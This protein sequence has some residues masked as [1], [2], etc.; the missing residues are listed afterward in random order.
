MDQ[1][2]FLLGPAQTQK[3][4]MS[5]E[6]RHMSQ[7]QDFMNNVIGQRKEDINQIGNIMANI[8]EM[9]KDIALETR[10]QGEKLE[11]L[12][13]NMAE[14]ENNADKAVDQLVSAEKNQKKAGKCTKCLIV[15]ILLLLIGL[16]CFVY[17]TFIKK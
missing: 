17:F 10:Q 3:F 6:D 7:N 14:A 2:D 15:M 4:K 13:Q 5:D 1:N 11:K 12:D 16:G 8:N 9:A